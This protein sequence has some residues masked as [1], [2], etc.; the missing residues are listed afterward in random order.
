MEISKDDIFQWVIRPTLCL[1][2]G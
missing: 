1:I 2:L